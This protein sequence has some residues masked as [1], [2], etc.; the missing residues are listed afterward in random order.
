MDAQLQALVDHIRSDLA[1]GRL[2]LPTLPDIVPRVS[3]LLD[4]PDCTGDAVARVVGKDPGLA[5]RFVRLANSAYFPNV[6]PVA[7]LRRA[8]VRL[9]N[10]IIKH[11]ITT[12][13]VSKLYDVRNH[14]LARPHLVELWHHSTLVASLSEVLARRL[15]HLEPEVAMLSGLVHRIGALPVIVWAERSPEVLRDRAR[16]AELVT[17][18]QR[19][20]G[21]AV[22]TSWRFAPAMVAVVDQCDDLTR[23]SVGLADYADLVQVATL[24]GY[25]GTDHAWGSVDWEQVPAVL[26]VGVDPA[27][28]EDL[29]GYAGVRV[30]ELRALLGPTGNPPSE[31]PVLRRRVS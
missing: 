10:N 6:R 16:T 27:E 17:I 8:V 18:L 3:R 15:A 19:E 20:V 1:A 14:P 11:L 13:G 30:G 25:R 26:A 2:V 9:G 22:L 31:A 7:D 12:L 23:E 21:R 5:A 24:I 4:S 28:A 29:K